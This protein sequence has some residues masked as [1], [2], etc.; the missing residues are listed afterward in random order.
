[1]A[2]EVANIGKLE[3][4]QPQQVKMAINRANTI[5]SIVVVQRFPH[6]VNSEMKSEFRRKSKV[7]NRQSRCDSEAQPRQ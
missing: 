2:R 4:L 1:M 3:L 7:K 5:N 6:R